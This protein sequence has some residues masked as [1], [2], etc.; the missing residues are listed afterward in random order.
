MI[1]MQWCVRTATQMIKINRKH[2]RLTEVLHFWAGILKIL[3]WHWE[4]FLDGQRLP[5]KRHSSAHFPSDFWLFPADFPLAT[6]LY[7]HSWRQNSSI[8]F[9]WE[10]GTNGNYVLGH[11]GF[12]SQFTIWS[13]WRLLGIHSCQYNSLRKCR[14]RKY[15]LPD[16]SKQ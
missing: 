16:D 13:V 2:I 4:K 10:L 3:P 1:V 9:S 6:I 11:K 7:N 8:R 14:F 15:L 12:F 5:P